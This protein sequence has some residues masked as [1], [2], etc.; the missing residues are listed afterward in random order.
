MTTDGP[1]QLAA[2]L[3]LSIIN[4][5]A[6]ISLPPCKV[7]DK[8]RAR[9][10][11][12][13]HR[14]RGKKQNTVAPASTIRARKAAGLQRS[15]GRERSAVEQAATLILH[16][17]PKPTTDLQGKE[18]TALSN[19]LRPDVSLRLSAMATCSSISVWCIR[20]NVTTSVRRR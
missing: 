12:Q 17:S 9:N 4:Q 10:P 8:R 3:K 1:I 16:Y 19:A 14:S 6:E 20:V 18:K 2:P 7:I 13:P 11:G 5:V 15:E